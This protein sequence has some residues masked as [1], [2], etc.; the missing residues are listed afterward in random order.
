MGDAAKAQG[1]F[2]E[3]RLGGGKALRVSIREWPFLVGRR[4]LCHLRLESRSVSR[5]HAELFFRGGEVFLRDLKSTNGTFLNG[6]RLTELEEPLRPG[7]L[8][9]FGDL[10][11]RLDREGTEEVEETSSSLDLFPPDRY[12]E[13][14]A[15][16]FREMLERR[17]VEPL[18]QPIVDLSTGKIHGYEVF[19]RGTV[20]GLPAEPESLFSIAQVL[21]LEADLSRLFWE[22]GL[23]R[24]RLLP[25]S[26]TLFINVHPSETGH[27]A[28]LEAIRAARDEQPA[29]A[30]T[31][32]VSEKAVTD[33]ESMR[34]LKEELLAL[35][36][37]LAYDDFGAGQARLLE[38]IEVPP[39]YLKFDASLVRHLPDKPKRYGKFLEVLVRITR[40]LGIASL[41]EGVETAGELEACR[42]LGFRYAQ[43]FHLGRPAR[44][45]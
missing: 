32:E 14:V 15:A 26:P 1:W 31:V 42:A 5:V 9:R 36:V 28:F 18:F 30:L 23:R 22:E 19:G 17:K 25:G 11:F 7:D 41:A 38:L 20:A 16:Q 10:E 6:L 40:D 33:P 21:G 3:G 39:H 34:R 43:G 37:F 27:P 35:D 44:V 24:G 13:S 12:V 8:I 45:A 4:T 2:L 29:L